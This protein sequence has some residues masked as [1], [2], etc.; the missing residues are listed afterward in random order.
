M[1]KRSAGNFSM[2]MSYGTQNTAVIFEEAVTREAKHELQREIREE[3]QEDFELKLHQKEI[4][5]QLKLNQQKDQSEAE[6]KE[7]IQKYERLILQFEADLEAE[8]ERTRRGSMDGVVLLEDEDTKTSEMM[9]ERDGENE[10]KRRG[11]VDV[12]GDHESDSV[13]SEQRRRD[14]ILE[15]DEQLRQDLAFFDRVDKLFTDSSLMWAMPLTK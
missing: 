10:N 11:S 15:I 2:P 12:F 7:L 3:L 1:G 14:D 8:R 5:L 13:D 4:E 6:K 9:E